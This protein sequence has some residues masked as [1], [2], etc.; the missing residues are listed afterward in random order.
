V[1]AA[2]KEVLLRGG[3]MAYRRKLTKME[4]REK[5]TSSIL[6]LLAHLPEAHKKIFIW[7]HYHGWHTERI[8]EKLKCNRADVEGILQQINVNLLHRA[9]TLIV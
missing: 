8:A 9:G 6:E 4:L 7:K 2:V 3:V 5:M 1:S